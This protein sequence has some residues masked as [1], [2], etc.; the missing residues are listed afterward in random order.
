MQLDRLKEEVAYFKFWQGIVAITDIS[1][2]GWLMSAVDAVDRLRAFL[3]V[4]G[5]ILLTFLAVVLH[6]QVDRRIKDIGEL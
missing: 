4:L 2:L 3:A 6:R 5:V 1:L